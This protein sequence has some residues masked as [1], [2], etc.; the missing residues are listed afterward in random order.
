MQVL[1]S[2]SHR[3]VRTV[4]ILR[5]ALEKYGL[6][7]WLDRHDM[8][9]GDEIVE[10]LRNEIARSDLVLVVITPYSLVSDWVLW[11]IEYCLQIERL[12]KVTKLIPILMRGNSVPSRIS[13]RMYVDFRTN[14]VMT[15]NFAKL[16]KQVLKAGGIQ[17]LEEP[18]IAYDRLNKEVLSTPEQ[19]TV[20]AY[21]VGT[22]Y[23]APSPQSKP[24][25]N[26]GTI[27]RKGDTLLIIEAMKLMNEIEAECD[28]SVADILVENGQAVEYGQP[29]ALL[30][31]PIKTA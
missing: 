28:G 10:R 7:V 6:Q 27:V 16:I 8:S 24:F 14:A 1:I 2:Y 25:V 5:K 19:I 30:T 15:A 17:P 22:V 13:R 11:E 26:I 20:T 4:D 9:F 23:L 21:I 31:A 18:R 3:D 29:L 12:Y